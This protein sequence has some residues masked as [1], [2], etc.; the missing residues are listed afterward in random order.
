[1]RI[2]GFE[3]GTRRIQRL[4]ENNPREEGIPLFLVFPPKSR[5]FPPV[6]G[7]RIR[8]QSQICGQ[9]ARIHRD[10][11]TSP[12]FFDGIIPGIA[13]PEAIPWDEGPGISGMW[14]KG[15]ENQELQLQLHPNKPYPWGRREFPTSSPLPA[16]TGIGIPLGA[17]PG[18]VLFPFSAGSGL[19]N[20][21]TPEVF[22]PGA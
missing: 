7:N 12:G 11:G 8:P 9:R 13:L 14:D 19:G 21:K 17:A 16:Q 22:P 15:M 2:L 1:M 10:Q 20:G 6:P 4:W 5:C 18:G 3:A